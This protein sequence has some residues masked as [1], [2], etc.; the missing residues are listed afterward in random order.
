MRKVPKK[1][2][3]K[4]C[5]WIKYFLIVGGKKIA[6]Q[7]GNAY[8]ALVCLFCAVSHGPYP[9]YSSNTGSL[10]SS[11]I[12]EIFLSGKKYQLFIFFCL[13]L[14]Y[15]VPAVVDPFSNYDCA[16]ICICLLKKVKKKY[17]TS[18]ISNKFRDVTG[19]ML[20]VEWNMNQHYAADH[21]M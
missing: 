16:F 6:F 5:L 19:T 3:P 12:P 4:G 10:I 2:K 7:R 8:H 13:I 21:G 1:Q 17:K 9:S 11:V 20:M 15:L 14:F 18:E